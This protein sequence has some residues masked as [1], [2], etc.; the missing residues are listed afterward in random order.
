MLKDVNLIN[1]VIPCCYS[2]ISSFLRNDNDKDDIFYLRVLSDFIQSFS[3]TFSEHKKKRKTAKAFECNMKNNSQHH[4]HCRTI[5]NCKSEEVKSPKRKLQKVINLF[6]MKMR[7]FTHNEGLWGESCERNN[8]NI[9]MRCLYRIMS[10]SI[11][12]DNLYAVFVVF[13]R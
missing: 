3:V 4:C 12:C 8:K 5:V 10:S 9:L 13:T 6:Q 7:K 1:L 11:C 2:N